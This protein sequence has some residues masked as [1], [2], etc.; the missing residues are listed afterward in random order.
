MMMTNNT[1]TATFIKIVVANL[2]V[3]ALLAS[4]MCSNDSSFG[5][6][7]SRKLQTTNLFFTIG[8]GKNTNATSAPVTRTPFTINLPSFFATP[9]ARQPFNFSNFFLGNPV[10]T[11]PTNTATP[12][13]VFQPGTYIINFANFNSNQNTGLSRLPGAGVSSTNVNDIRGAINA[14]SNAI[15]AGQGF[16]QFPIQP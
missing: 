16:A 11:N 13:P 2:M 15:I 14:S 3:A 10:P 4:Y 1:S 8:P 6:K 9:Q 7:G 12:T 5:L